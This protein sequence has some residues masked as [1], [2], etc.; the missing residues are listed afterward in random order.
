MI[1]FIQAHSSGSQPLS[2][3]TEKQPA[4]WLKTKLRL[5]CAAFVVMT[6]LA[7]ANASEA[8]DSSD[9]ALVSDY[10]LASDTQGEALN[11]NDAAAQSID[12]AGVTIPTADRCALL[13]AQ[14]CMFR[15]NYAAEIDQPNGA[16][17]AYGPPDPAEQAAIAQKHE[18]YKSFGSQIGAVKWEMAAILGYY[19]AINGGKLFEDP[20]WPHFHTEGW[21]GAD[22]KNLGVDKLAHA[23]SAYVLSDL[24]YY[25]LKRKTG[26]APGIALTAAVLA[27]TTMLYTEVWDS[28]EKSAGWS[29]EDVAFN[30]LGAGFSLV[31]N[32]VPGLDKKLDYRMMIVPNSNIINTQ[33]KRHFEQQRYFFALKLG[34]F[35]ALE[36]SPLRFLDLHLGYYGKDFTNEDRA[37]GVIPKRRIFVGVG[38]NI[39]E[40][41]FKN[42]KSRIGR[43]AGEAMDYFQLPYTALHTHLTN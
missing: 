34:G 25:R 21:F 37:A 31:R 33:G 15:A 11:R 1:A 6:P 41:F 26:S 5:A 12:V 29:W 38:L 27:S 36:K 22:T 14:G 39:R 28:I 7:A 40:L 8:A 35:E 19:T 23:Y 17:G 2:K 16:N 32:A 4:K 30:S 13:P 20:T 24:I 42:S 18:R 9:L 43:A 10:R 3:V